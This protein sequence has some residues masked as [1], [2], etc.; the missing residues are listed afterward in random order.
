MTLQ[1]Q[2]F[3]QD[4]RDNGENKKACAMYQLRHLTKLGAR[5]K[6]NYFER[7]VFNYLF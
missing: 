5:H 2:L 6:K 1:A 3:R 4:E 7:Q